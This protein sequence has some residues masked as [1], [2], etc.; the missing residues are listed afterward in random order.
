MKIVA[1]RKSEQNQAI[2][3]PWTVVHFGAGLALGLVSMPKAPA[4]GM[5]VGYE[6]V[7]Q[8]AER[9]E[10]GQEFFDVSGP[11]SLPNAIVDVAVFAMGFYLG[12]LW[13]RS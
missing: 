12:K 7:E 11:E 9:R 5:A 10:L 6:L 2:L 13:N 1:T 3:D 4:I 8:W